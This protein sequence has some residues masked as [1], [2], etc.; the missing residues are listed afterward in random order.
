MGIEID[1]ISVMGSKFSWLLSGLV[2]ASGSNF[3]CFYAG[4]KIDFGCVRAENYLVLSYGSKLTWLLAWGSKL[5]SVLF[6]GR[7]LFGLNLLS[8]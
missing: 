3:T 7:K 1:F 8:T 5:T 4:V 6:A 2:L